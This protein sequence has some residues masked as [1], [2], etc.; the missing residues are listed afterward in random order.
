MKKLAYSMIPQRLHFVITGEV[1]SGVSFVARRDHLF[2]IFTVTFSAL[3]ALAVGTWLGIGFFQ[4][5][6]SLA[7][8]T[9]LQADALRELTGSFEKKL[10]EQLAEQQHIWNTKENAYHAEIQHL[11]EERENII[12]RYEEEIAS[13]DVSTAIKISGL[14]AEL[15]QEKQEKQDLLEK[16]AVRLD[17]RSRMIESVMSRIGVDVKVGKKRTANSGGPFIAIDKKYSQNLLSRSDKYIK[18]IRKMPLGYPMRGKITSAFGRRSD[19]FNNRP[20]FHAGI[21]LKGSIGQKINATADGIVKTSSYDKNGFGNYVVLLH[22]N[23]YETVFGHMQK[24]LV[25]K[26][27]RVQRGQVVGLMGNTG[28]STGPHLH[29]EVRYKGKP[30]NPKK[31]LSV[32]KL[33]FTVPE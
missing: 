1:G 18:T 23:G 14:L 33:S 4:E 16:T 28:R 8:K 3:T 13:A 25:K 29:Y 27:E 5:R 11:K 10:R 2:I 17:E 30:I 15:E 21:D 26:G 32:A 19:P 12:C 22:G 7:L 20:A 24:R 9:S 6:N 31:Y